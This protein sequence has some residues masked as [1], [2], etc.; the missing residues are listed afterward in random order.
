MK[1]S[2]NNKANRDSGNTSTIILL[3]ESSFVGEEVAG[4]VWGCGFVKICCFNGLLGKVL[5][6]ASCS[7]RGCACLLHRTCTQVWG[8]GSYHGPGNQPQLSIA[9]VASH[10]PTS[11]SP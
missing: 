8:R 7:V 6:S 3:I 1:N 10:N 5:M 4:G 2:C 9:V 11:Q